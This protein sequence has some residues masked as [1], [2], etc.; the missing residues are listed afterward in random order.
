MHCEFMR[1]AVTSAGIAMARGAVLGRAIVRVTSE[2]AR[3]AAVFPFKWV[4]LGLIAERL[5][6]RCLLMADSVADHVCT[7]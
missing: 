4:K 5:L 7:S 6:L 1:N 2:S 3:N